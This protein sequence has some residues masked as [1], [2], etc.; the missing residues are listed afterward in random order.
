M[1]RRHL[2]LR[3]VRRALRSESAIVVVGESNGFDLH[4]VTS[5]QRPGLWEQLRR[6]YQGPGGTGG[7]YM[8]YEFVD[9]SGARMLYLEKGC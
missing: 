1:S 3:V 9:N 8:G 6:S 4:W 7:D 2:D 5:E